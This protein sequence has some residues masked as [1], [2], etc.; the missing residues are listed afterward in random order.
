MGQDAD[1]SVR[2]KAAVLLE[3]AARNYSLID[4][5]KR[6]TWMAAFVFFGLNGVDLDAPEDDAYDLVIA[7][8]TGSVGDGHQCL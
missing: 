8:S 4:G 3:S 1:P 6:L 2:E 5:N 7:V